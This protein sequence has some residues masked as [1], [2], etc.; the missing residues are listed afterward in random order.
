MDAFRGHVVEPEQRLFA[1]EDVQREHATDLHT[2]KI[3]GKHLESQAEDV[4]NRKR[5][6]NLCILGLP[7]GAN[8]LCSLRIS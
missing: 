1:S 6:N 8:P 4:E 3:R 2:L 7:E 5:R